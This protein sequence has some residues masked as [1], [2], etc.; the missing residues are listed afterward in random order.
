MG[1]PNHQMGARRGSGVGV[2]AKLV[3]EKTP[4]KWMVT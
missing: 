4:L 2:Q 1:N 3:K